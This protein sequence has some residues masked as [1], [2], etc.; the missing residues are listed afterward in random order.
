[1]REPMVGKIVF[2]LLAILCLPLEAWSYDAAMLQ[3]DA[4][5]FLSAEDLMHRDLSSSIAAL[6]KSQPLLSPGTAPGLSADLSLGDIIAPSFEYR[7]LLSGAGPFVTLVDSSDAASIEAVSAGG[8]IAFPSGLSLTFNASYLPPINMNS[9]EKSLFRIGASG[10][11]RL[12]PERFHSVGA[13]VGGGASYVRGTEMRSIDTSFADS[14]TIRS[15]SGLLDSEWNY[16]ILDL[17]LFVHKTFFI[18]NFYTRANICLILGS[19]SSS[20]SDIKV[21]GTAIPEAQA[22]Y[23]SDLQAPAAG[24]VLAGGMELILGELKLTAEAGRD[25]LSASFYGSIGLRFGT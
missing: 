12:L 14:S 15:F 11:W 24:L 23:S 19:S 7:S 5:A 20:L 1:M 13:L 22:K 25:W 9:A 16:G 17:E 8:A 6:R 18:V 3:T 21:D 2:A 4:S 10:Y